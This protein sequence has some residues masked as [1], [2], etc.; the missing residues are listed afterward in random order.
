MGADCESRYWDEFMDVLNAHKREN[1]NV[2][3][4]FQSLGL[5]NF[6]D[7]WNRKRI[8]GLSAD[9]QVVP[10]VSYK[11]LH[12]WLSDMYSSSCTWDEYGSG[13]AITG[14]EWPI[15]GRNRVPEFGDFVKEQSRLVFEQ[16]PLQV[17]GKF[18]EMFDHVNVLTCEY[19]NHARVWPSILSRVA[20]AFECCVFQ[21]RQIR[22]W[23]L[24]P[25]RLYVHPRTRLK[26]PCATRR[27]HTT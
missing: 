16:N 19:M 27:S 12:N 18:V 26:T 17:Y 25:R 3:F 24:S 23:M 2:L 14:P 15:D 7:E 13:F 5:V 22:L 21:S 4:S 8:L 11:D 10:I 1:H 20:D 9:W 6:D